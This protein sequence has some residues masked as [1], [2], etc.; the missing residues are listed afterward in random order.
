[1]SIDPIERIAEERLY[2]LSVDLQVQLEKGTGT[3]PILWM[4]VQARKKAA[5]A[6][7]QLVL[8]D[9]EKPAD[10]R[11]C[12]A[13]ILLYDDLIDLC[14]ALLKRGKEADYRIH[15]SDREELADLTRDLSPEEQR[16][17]GLEPEGTDL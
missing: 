15:E 13:A 8:A 16:M 17:T 12:Q 7:T 1:M 4:L 6:T 11:K 10:I 5:A 14:R 9:A 2:E 3:R